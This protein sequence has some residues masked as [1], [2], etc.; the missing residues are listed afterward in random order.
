MKEG[1]KYLEIVL[2]NG[3]RFSVKGETV[4][5]VPSNVFNRQQWAL[6]E[7]FNGGIAQIWAEEIVA[8]YERKFI[9]HDLPF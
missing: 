8:V 5:D 2:K 9:Y 6:F 4:N 3:D 1:E 7:L